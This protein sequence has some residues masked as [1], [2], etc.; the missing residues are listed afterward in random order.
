MQRVIESKQP[1]IVEHTHTG[2]DGETILVEVAAAPIVGDDGEVVQ[3]IETIR[4]ITE[5]KRAEEERLAL[6]RQVQHT[7]KLES[8]GILAGGIAH[9]FNNILMAI[10]GNA[11]LA[12]RDLSPM[13]PARD[14]IKEIEKASRRAADL[15]KQMLAY[16][17]R[18]K[19]VV[20]PID[21]GELVEEIS[22]LLE[23]SISK[24][25]V[26]KYNMAEKLPTFD[27]DVTQIRQVIMN[28]IINASEAIGSRSGVIVLSTGVMYCNEIYLSG[29]NEVLRATLDEP[30]PEGQYVY[31]EVA[32][33]GCGMDKETMK[34]VFDPF[35]TT[36]FTGRGL[37][38]SA[39]LGIVRGHRGP[40]KVSS[41]LGKG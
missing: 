28:L 10:L 12:L 18:G 1:V 21:L 4:D 8:L 40:I 31:F 34:K 14:N 9:D 3:I 23:V 25:V 35:F 26:L 24:K 37:G 2:S 22:Y 36:K 20:Q 33:N 29:V 32:D 19:F 7:Q 16:S 39:V 5:R 11:D 17:G 13:S 6:D 27:G 41:D 30:L 38:M 15:A